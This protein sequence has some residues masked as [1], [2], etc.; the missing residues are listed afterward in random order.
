[1]YLYHASELLLK[2]YYTSDMSEI[3]VKGLNYYT[4]VYGLN[5]RKLN[6]RC[7]GVL[8][9]VMEIYGRLLQRYP[10]ISCGI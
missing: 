7:S 2:I 1:M 10:C 4:V 5:S 9:C 8:E 3:S 6:E